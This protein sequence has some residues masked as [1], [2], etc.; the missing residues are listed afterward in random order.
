MQGGLS[1]GNVVRGVLLRPG[2][3]SEDGR[4]L[5][6]AGT[7]APGAA[8]LI[9][10]NV[11]RGLSRLGKRSLPSCLLQ[12]GR[13]WG[14]QG[15][16]TPRGYPAPPPG[17]HS[18]PRPCPCPVPEDKA[19]T[20]MQAEVPETGGVIRK[21]TQVPKPPAPQRRS[22]ACCVSPAGRPRGAGQ[23]PVSPLTGSPVP[24]GPKGRLAAVLG[25]GKPCSAAGPE[26]GFL[27]GA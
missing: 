16:R 22:P 17:T 13:G 20:R 24:G 1:P 10:A 26:E 18:S 9:S 7:G 12:R 4:L 27:D 15:S 8:H 11:G 6:P 23:I 5:S 3:K 21:L 25:R 19:R 14:P 2:C